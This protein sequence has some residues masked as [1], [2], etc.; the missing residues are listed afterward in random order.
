MTWEVGPTVLTCRWLDV[1]MAFQLD[2][3]TPWWRL[4]HPG[5]ARG[6]GHLVV[7]SG[8]PIRAKK[9]RVTRGA[10]LCA[11]PATLPARK[12]DSDVRFRCRFHQWLRLFLLYTVVW[13]KH[14]F[15]NFHFWAK[16]K[17]HFKPNALIPIVG[18]SVSPCADRW[19]T[20]SCLMEVKHTE[21]QYLMWFGK[22]AYIYGRESILLE[23]EKGNN[24]NTWRRRITSLKLNYQLS[25]TAAHGSNS[26]FSLIL[27]IALTTFSLSAQFALLSCCLF[28]GKNGATAPALLQQRWLPTPSLLQ[29]WWLPKSMVGAIHLLHI[30]GN[31]PN[32]WWASIPY[33]FIL[34][35]SLRRTSLTLSQIHQ[36]FRRGQ[37]MKSF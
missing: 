22:T 11:W 3:L 4:S 36:N 35:L 15:D 9:T 1:D 23:I 5:L 31:K 28:I 37:I 18:D 25:H 26:S 29:Q 32:T 21:T 20:D 6:L 2:M 14:N 8:Q 33:A 30:N 12:D 34:V 10:C 7:G 13:S 27:S 19:C 16:I 24:R 17:H